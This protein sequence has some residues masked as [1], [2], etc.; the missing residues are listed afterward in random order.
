[1]ITEQEQKVIRQ[2]L[3]ICRL[4]YNLMDDSED[5]GSEKLLVPR[6]SFDELSKAMDQLNELPDDKPNYVLNES[7]RAGWALRGILPDEE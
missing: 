4:A 2:L 1:M 6:D 7:G 5:D 3:E